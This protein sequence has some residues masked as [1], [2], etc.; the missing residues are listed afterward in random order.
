MAL[1][2]NERKEK[3]KFSKLRIWVYAPPFSGKTHFAD[4]APNPLMLNTD[5]NY[6]T[7]TAPYVDLRTKH[8]VGKDGKTKTVWGW[9]VFKK[10]VDDLA[11]EGRS[12]GYETIVVDL[13]ENV[14]ELARERVLFD[15]NATHESDGAY[16]KLWGLPDEELFKQL[17][18][19]ASLDFNLIFCSHE[20]TS[21]DLSLGDSKSTVFAPN[22]KDKTARQI[23]G[24]MDITARIDPDNH[25]IKF[26][27][28]KSIFGGNRI[29]AG[30]MDMCKNNWDD[31]IKYIESNI[32]KGK[33]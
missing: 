27:H 6:D 33:I 25:M 23:A 26:A 12:S 24:M 7:F 14:R 22:I 4:T 13:V 9:D 19:L 17:K 20:D 31:L 5:G 30:N 15:N 29:G 1:P 3:K 16:G 18:K 10:T 28:S 21:R 32:V 8:E 2:K 11:I